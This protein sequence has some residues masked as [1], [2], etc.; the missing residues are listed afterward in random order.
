MGDTGI[1]RADHQMGGP[2]PGLVRPGGQV[3]FSTIN[4]NPK[5]FAFA[6]VGA[7]Y[8]LKILPA[9]THEYQKFI[10]P[11]ELEEWA[12]SASLVFKSSMGLHYNPLTARYWLAPNLDVNYMMHFERPDTA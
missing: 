11:S 7:E 5:S 9:G 3:V 4:R 8:L 12:R 10:K 1:D 6:I 2:D